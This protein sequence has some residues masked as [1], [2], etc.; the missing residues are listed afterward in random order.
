MWHD[1]FARTGRLY[2]ILCHA[3]KALQ[4]VLREK[5]GQEPTLE[6]LIKKALRQAGR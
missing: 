3:E 5:A 2:E 4:T 6:E 1:N